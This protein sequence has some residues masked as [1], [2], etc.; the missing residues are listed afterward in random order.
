VTTVLVTG[1]GGFVGTHLVRALSD[2]L[3]KEVHHRPSP[4]ADLTVELAG[5]PDWSEVLAG[6]DAV[7]HLAARVHVSGT[8][9]GAADAF[10]LVNREGTLRLAEAAQSA[11]VRRFVFLSTAGVVGRKT[12]APATETDEIRPMSPYAASKAEAERALQALAGEMET[13]IL[14]P[15]LVYGPGAPGSF[16]RLL[17]LIQR[18]VPLPLGSARSKRSVIY[19]G[20]LVDAI[21]R[22]VLA[23]TASGTYF[24]SDGRD[25]SAKQLARRVGHHLGK[26]ARLVPVHPAFA[27]VAGTMIGRSVDVSRLFDEFQVNL[28]SFSSDFSWSPPFSLDEGL[29]LS[30]EE[31]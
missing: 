4:A 10:T 23:S 31:G 9:R 26:P 7:V 17:R 11:K 21:R 29:R 25:V 24:V 3:V 14:R 8:A 19:V 27:R 12:D 1:A 20:N 18:G 15:P 30:V 13:V 5:Q 22:C 16:G 6:V 2:C 28:S